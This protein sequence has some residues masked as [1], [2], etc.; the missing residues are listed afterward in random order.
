[1][2]RCSALIMHT[3]PLLPVAVGLISGVVVDHWLHASATVAFAAL[4]GTSVVL[5][6]RSAREAAGPLLILLASTSVGCLLHARAM[7]TVPP[8]SIERYVG[9]RGQIARLRGRVVSAPRIVGP[10]SNPFSRWS[11]GSDRTVFLLEA[12]SLEGERGDVLVTGRVRVSVGEVLFDIR[13]PR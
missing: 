9:A 6:V 3:A 13:E 5:L 2:K 7:R 11:Y 10:P 1:M 8:S 12:E 4:T